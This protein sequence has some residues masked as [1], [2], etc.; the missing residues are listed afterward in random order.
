[1]N[2]LRL[3]MSIVWRDLTGEFGCKDERVFQDR[4][5]LYSHGT[6]GCSR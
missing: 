2:D 6:T 3:C 4:E 5:S 1:M